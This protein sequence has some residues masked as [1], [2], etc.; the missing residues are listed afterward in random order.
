MTQ[1]KI[2]SMSFKTLYPLYLNKVMKKGR[3]EDELKKVIEWLTGYKPSELDK[4]DVAEKTLQQFFETAPSLN[5]NRNQ[6]TGNI[7][8]VRVEEITEPLMRDIRCL[9]KLVDE[10]AK[11]KALL[12]ILR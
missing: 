2:Y 6:I 10:L 9:D 4:K 12:S 3:S 7:C 11:G 8:G 1:S 5:P